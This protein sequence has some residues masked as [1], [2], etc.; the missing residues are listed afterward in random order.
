MKS[1]NNLLEFF[2]KQILTEKQIV[3]SLD[4]ALG[5]VKNPAVKMVLRGI[6]L[7]SVKHAEMYSAA[8]GLLS[9][10][11]V[12]LREDDFNNLSKLVEKHIHLEE[13]LISL[14]GGV[15]DSVDDDRIEM[16]L[17]AIFEDEK[18]HHKLLK[19]IME[20]LVKRETITD[21]EWFDFLQKSVPFHGAP[22]G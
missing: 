20:A 12:A 13:K 1:K 19:S 15:I 10:T 5:T 16:L 8:I 22:G 18:R 6:S 21:N 4:S 2:K 11:L 7:D 14:M 9:K 17:K 3:A